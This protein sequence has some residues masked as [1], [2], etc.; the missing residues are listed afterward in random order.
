MIAAGNRVSLEFTL[1]L[2]SGKVV[3]TTVGAEP[4]V[5]TH[6]GEQIP[7][8]LERQLEGLRVGDHREITLSPEEAYGAVDPAAFTKI[9][10]EALPEKARKPGTPVEVGEA[11]GSSRIARVHEVFADH[12]VLNLNHALAGERLTFNVHVLGVEALVQGGQEAAAR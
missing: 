6:G 7:P 11:G 8:V 3:T 9:D 12:V 2:D 5:Y 1:T 10:I 4:F